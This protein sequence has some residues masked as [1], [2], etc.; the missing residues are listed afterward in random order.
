MTKAIDWTGIPVD[1]RAALEALAAELPGVR[2]TNESPALLEGLLPEGRGV[3]LFGE[4]ATLAPRV[5][6]LPESLGL[7]TIGGWDPTREDGASSF[8]VG[9]G[10][11]DPEW[12]PLPTEQERAAWAA[13]DAEPEPEPAPID[14]RRAAARF[15]EQALNNAGGGNVARALL[16]QLEF[17]PA[18]I[19]ALLEGAERIAADPGRRVRARVV[20]WVTI[21]PDCEHGPHANVWEAP[22]C[23]GET[24]RAAGFAPMDSSGEQ[25]VWCKDNGREMN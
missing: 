19:G 11:P 12:E 15:A 7:H 1:V 14:R 16:E 23:F 9:W 2:L 10:E 5:D 8:C 17:P 4:R 13:E 6:A 20:R 22:A 24:L 25:W 3:W 18:A 21:M